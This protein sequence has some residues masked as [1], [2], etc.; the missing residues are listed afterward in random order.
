MI[1]SNMGREIGRCD[2]LED[3]AMMSWLCRL[4]AAFPAQSRRNW[5]HSLKPNGIADV[6]GVTLRRCKGGASTIPIAAPGIPRLSSIR[7]Q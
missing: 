7:L 2:A 3:L 1:N 6:I 4:G 5:R